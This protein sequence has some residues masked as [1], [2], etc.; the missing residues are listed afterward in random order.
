M[1][2]W[3]F[4]HEFGSITVRRLAYPDGNDEPDWIYSRKRSDWMGDKEAQ[5]EEIQS[6]EA[7]FGD[8]I[9]LESA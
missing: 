9:H 8:L 3:V 1:P 7:I 4:H 2:T 5:L 6:I